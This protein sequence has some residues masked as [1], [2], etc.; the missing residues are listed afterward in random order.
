MRDYHFMT[1]EDFVNRFER[2]E[3]LEAMHYLGNAYGTLRSDIEDAKTRGDILLWI[4]DV[5]GVKS[6]KEKLKNACYIFIQPDKSEHLHKRLNDRGFS[7]KDM[8]QRIEQAEWEIDQTHLYDHV[9]TNEHGQ[10]QKTVDE[11][12]G[13]IR[14]NI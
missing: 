3:F 9:V 10:M 7:E 5:K 1:T 11:I 14:K 2:D 12:A 8:R 13:I 4:L 6:V